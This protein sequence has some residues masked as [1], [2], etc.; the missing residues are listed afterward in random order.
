[1]PSMHRFQCASQ[2]GCWVLRRLAGSDCVQKNLRR[3]LLHSMRSSYRAAISIRR[4]RVRIVAAETCSR[5]Q[6]PIDGNMFA[7]SRRSVV[8]ACS[9]VQFDRFNSCHSRATR[10][11]V[12][13][14]VLLVNRLAAPGSKP[15]ASC[16]LAASHFFRA[17]PSEVSG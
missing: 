7:S 12:G 2:Y 9:S 8:L 1:M 14:S 6:S 4:K 5:R 15:V 13:M 11:N 17:Y 10:S 16:S 3:D